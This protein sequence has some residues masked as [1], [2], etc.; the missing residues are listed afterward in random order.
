MS[1]GLFCLNEITA[2]NILR[3]KSYK[4][5]QDVLPGCAFIG[6]L[7]L[8]DV[9]PNTWSTVALISRFT[10]RN[11]KK[12]ELTKGDAKNFSRTC[13]VDSTTCI[14]ISP[15]FSTSETF[16]TSAPSEFLLKKTIMV[17]FL[18]L[19][20]CEISTD[21]YRLLKLL[22]ALPGSTGSQSGMC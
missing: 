14:L 4:D 13:A 2:I 22:D 21:T 12:S 10:G 7:H 6:T 11:V 18:C 17:G 15:F 19:T 8:T 3:Y 16:E 9:K 5:L 20:N 1:K